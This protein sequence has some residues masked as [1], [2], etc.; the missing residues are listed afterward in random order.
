MGYITRGRGGSVHRKDCPNVRTLEQE[1]GRL[2]DVNWYSAGNVAYTA[3]ITV[4]ANDR[5][6]LLMEITNCIGEDRI[7][8]TA[9]NARTNKDRVAVINLTIEI[10]DTEQLERLIKELRMIPDVFEVTRTKS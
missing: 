9:I 1:S 6:A 5:T 2:I 3:N 4:L 10:T 7:N 8:L